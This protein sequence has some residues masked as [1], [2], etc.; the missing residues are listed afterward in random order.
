MKCESGIQIDTNYLKM[1]ET[2]K[3]KQEE[4]EDEQKTITIEGSLF[5]LLG[6]LYAVAAVTRGRG[7]GVLPSPGESPADGVPVSGNEL[8]RDVRGIGFGGD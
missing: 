1:V 7:R 3:R 4:E 8:L 6:T 2:T 5:I